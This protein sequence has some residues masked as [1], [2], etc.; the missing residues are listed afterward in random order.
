MHA[1]AST[2]RSSTIR[3]LMADSSKENPG[4]VTGVLGRVPET[5]GQNR[6]VIVI[7]TRLVLTDSLVLEGALSPKR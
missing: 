2:H 4:A 3:C 1:A 7:L 6:Y 5:T